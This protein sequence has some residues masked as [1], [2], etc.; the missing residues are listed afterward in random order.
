[1]DQ[2]RRDICI[3]LV[4][5]VLQI[6]LLYYFWETNIILTVLLMLVS[7]IV[8]IKFTNTAEKIFYF[9]GFVSIPIFDLIIV[10]RS[11]WTYGNPF[12]F[13]IPLWLPVGYG[14]STVM[15]VKIGNSIARLI[16]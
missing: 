15:I 3:G 10:P 1:M 4:V 5:F 6:L 16:K 11:A 13:G 12:I 2:A 7:A 14:L 9:L 8:L